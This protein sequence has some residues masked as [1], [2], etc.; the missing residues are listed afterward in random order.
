MSN[1]DISYGE[2]ILIDTFDAGAGIVGAAQAAVAYAIQKDTHGHQPLVAISA[3]TFYFSNNLSIGGQINL[4][5]TINFNELDV[6]GDATLDAS[7]NV[8]GNSY[9]R[10]KLEVNE[11]GA[12]EKATTGGVDTFR[13]AN[14]DNIS[15][16]S[17]ALLQMK[18]GETAINSG[19]NLSLKIGGDDMLSINAAGNVGIGTTNPSKSLEVNGDI[20]CED[21]SA[22]GNVDVTGN[23]NI[24]G[25][26][27]RGADSMMTYVQTITPDS[28]QNIGAQNNDSLMFITFLNSFTA[29]GIHHTTSGSLFANTNDGMTHLRLN[30]ELGA[31]A[32][33]TATR[34]YFV[35][36]VYTYYG[37]SSIA[38]PGSFLRKYYVDGGYARALTVDNDEFRI[39]GNIDLYLNKNTQFEIVVKK[40]Y[41]DKDDGTFRSVIL[42][43]VNSQLIIEKIH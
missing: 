27:Q 6:S 9:L 34:H 4:L 1:V 7:L 20:I 41:G 24:T 40:L 19:N 22:A 14:I 18:T 15:D 23:V 29:E 37:S 25:E 31:D 35:C 10:G 43:P 16:I 36:Y 13:L 3:E 11:I 26:L 2:L 28:N 33:E 42:S 5:G 12:L 21:L 39:G 30:I 38:T 17:Y 8:K 32:M